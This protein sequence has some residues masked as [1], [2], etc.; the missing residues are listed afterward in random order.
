[1]LSGYFLFLVRMLFSEVLKRWVVMKLD[2]QIK[3]IRG[4]IKELEMKRGLIYEALSFK[5]DESD[6]LD[7]LAKVTD[8]I[9]NFDEVVGTLEKMLI[10]AVSKL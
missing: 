3:F 6:K 4:K 1:M 5:E 10:W 2:D 9:N 7:E 8:E